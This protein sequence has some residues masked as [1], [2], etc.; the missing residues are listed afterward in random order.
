[1]RLLLPRLSEVCPERCGTRTLRVRALEDPSW[2][3]G[4]NSAEW[5][6]A[7][8]KSLSGA[9]LAGASISSNLEHLNSDFQGHTGLREVAGRAWKEF[10]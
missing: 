10:T 1:M 4:A 8:I 6:D 2:T 9:L 3:G 7:I 5:M